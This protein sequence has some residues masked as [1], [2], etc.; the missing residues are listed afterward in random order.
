[1]DKISIIIPA[2]N[3]EKYLEKCL[4]SILKG[5]ESGL[6]TEIF[7]VD[8]KS[9]DRTVQIV[10]QISESSPN[11]YLITNEKKTTPHAINLGIKKS[12]GDYLFIISAHAE[13][14]ADYFVKL[15]NWAKKLQAQV[16]GGVLETKTLDHSSKAKAIQ[17]VLSNKWGVGNALFRTG[18]KKVCEV[19]TV[20]FGCYHKSV[21]EKFGF[22]NPEL[23]RNQDI[24]F[25]LRIKKGGGKIYLVPD[26]KATY[27]ARNNFYALA[28]NNFK[29]G[30]WNILTLYYTRN[31]K[32]LSLRHFVP[33]VFVLS[34]LLPILLSVFYSPLILFSFFIFFVYLGFIF[35]VSLRSKPKTVNLFSILASFLILHFSYGL[36]SVSGIIK[37]IIL[38]FRKQKND[39]SDN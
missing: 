8:G 19:D 16:V 32:A 2:R 28:K 22:F 15:L 39:P 13:Y 26:V 24:E 38:F 21:F 1:M 35:F 14:P 3:E 23:T 20:A 31:F 27:Y 30:L 7:V 5:T 11:L 10:E 4:L 25:N 17:F 36:G 33:M 6:E 9:S 37:T 29:N 18:V 12:S 34:I